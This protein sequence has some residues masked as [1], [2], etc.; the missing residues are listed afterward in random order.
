MLMFAKDEQPLN[1]WVSMK[2]KPSLKAMD[3][4]PVQFS[5]APLKTSS[6]VSGASTLLRLTLSLKA[7]S[8][9]VSIITPS[10]FFG[11]TTLSEAPS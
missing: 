5:K 3:S 8:P 1:A 10:H 9:I 2:C 6:I 7:F 11:R 4:N